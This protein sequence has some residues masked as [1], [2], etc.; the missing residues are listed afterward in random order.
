MSGERRALLLITCQD[1][2]LTE[3]HRSSVAPLLPISVWFHTDTPKQSERSGA[4]ALGCHRENG[5][6]SL[7]GTNPSLGDDSPGD[8]GKLC[9]HR[10]FVVPADGEE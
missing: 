8:Q 6:R 3:I 2:A 7:L 9:S 1:D 10:F 4:G 5:A